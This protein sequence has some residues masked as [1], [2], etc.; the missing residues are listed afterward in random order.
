MLMCAMQ[1]NYHP[2]KSNRMRAAIKYYLEGDTE[3]LKSFPGGS[4][5][6]T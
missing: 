6:G 3:A 1:M 4:E 5:P 2:D